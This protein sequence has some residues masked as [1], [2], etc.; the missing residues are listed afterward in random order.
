MKV[1]FFNASFLKGPTELPEHKVEIELKN[2]LKL[3]ISE[4]PIGNSFKIVARIN[5]GEVGKPGVACIS[6]DGRLLYSWQKN[7]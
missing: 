6:D 7:T 4:D 1:N 2:G 5:D 3:T